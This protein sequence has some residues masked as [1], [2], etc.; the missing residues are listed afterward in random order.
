[1][2]SSPPG[3]FPDIHQLIACTTVEL[4]APHTSSTSAPHL[5]SVAPGLG[6][7]QGKSG[8]TS[9]HRISVPFL[10][11]QGMWHKGMC[12]DSTEE[13]LID[14]EGQAGKE[15]FWLNYVEAVH[16]HKCHIQ[17]LQANVSKNQRLMYE[18]LL[19]S[20]KIAEIHLNPVGNSVFAFLL[21]LIAT[22]IFKKYVLNLRPLQL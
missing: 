9:F 19:L 2:P 10:P 16:K 17:A 15:G 22:Q 20:P 3:R 11:W 5:F 1:M 4:L 7:S 8:S 18:N 13:P 21:W 12:Q 6:S 14:E